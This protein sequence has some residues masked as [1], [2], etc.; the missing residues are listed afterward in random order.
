M[1]NNLINSLKNGSELV[2]ISSDP[3]SNSA[4]FWMDNNGTIFS[5]TR[6]FGTMKRT[7]LNLTDL[8]M[9]LKNMKAEN[10]HIFIRGYR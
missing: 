10:A 6:A 1:A 8:E 2:I 5:F 3:G 9:H 4:I 7:D